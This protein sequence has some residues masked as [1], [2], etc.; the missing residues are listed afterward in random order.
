MP[1][2]LTT[3]TQTPFQHRKADTKPSML[4]WSGSLAMMGL[5]ALGLGACGGSPSGRVSVGGTGTSEF[6]LLFLADDGVPGREVRKPDGTVM[7]KDINPSGDSYAL[8]GD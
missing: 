8:V 3:H 7:L 1:V 6:P 5:L 4:R 2:H